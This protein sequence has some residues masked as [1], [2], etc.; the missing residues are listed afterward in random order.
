MAMAHQ[1]FPAS[2]RIAA[3]LRHAQLLRATGQLDKAIDSIAN[4][5]R[6][7]PNAFG[8]QVEAAETIQASA[9]EAQD[10]VRLADAVDGPRE[11]AIWGWNKLVTTLYSARKSDDPSDPTV[12]RLMKSQY[13]LANC[14][15]LIAK[16]TGDPGKRAELVAQLKKLVARLEPNMKRDV[17][18]WYDRFAELAAEVNRLE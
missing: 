8:L 6:D 2:S 1:D 9:L 7:N 13:Q 10:F 11:S 14:K 3:L 15:W 17:Q 5:L 16:A 18:P 12:Q 4:V